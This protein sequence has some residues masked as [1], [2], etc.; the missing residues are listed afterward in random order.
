MHSPLWFTFHDELGHLRTAADIHRTGHLFAHNPI[1]RA[2]P[3]FPVL[4]MVASALAN[5]SGLSI[6][7]SGLIV[8]G[9]ARLVTVVALFRVYEFVM[10]SRAAALATILYASN[11]TF[12]YFDGQFSYESLAVALAPIV[13][14]GIVR[15]ARVPGIV[16]GATLAVGVVLT[17]HLTSYALCAFLAVW[18]VLAVVA[19][20]R[21]DEAGAVVIAAVA[22]VAI[23][24]AVAWA[25][26]AAPVTSGYIAPV[27][28]NAAHALV[29]LTGGDAAVKRPFQG[30]G[31][32]ARPVWERAASIGSIV[33]ISIGVLVGLG[34][35]VRRRPGALG[36]ALALTGAAYP[37]TLVPRLTQAGT[38]IS[39]RSSGFVFVGVGYLLALVMIRAVPAPLHRRVHHIRWGLASLA[40]LAVLF[41]GGVGI[42]WAPAA[43]QPGPFMP[44]ANSR[45]IDTP[46]RWAAIWARSHLQAG[47][48]L[49]GDLDSSLLM[50]A[51]A[52][53]NPQ[54]GVISGIPVS[55]LFTSTRLGP[56]ERR[57]IVGDQ[58]RYIVVD[59]RLSGA[60]PGVGFY[61]T[62]TEPGA[63]HHS[64]PIPK[65]ALEKFH[66]APFLDEVFSDGRISIYDTRHLL[67]GGS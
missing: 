64:H 17:H 26:L 9:V 19:R 2:S 45:S 34:A 23:V 35:A 65:P 37:L 60:L 42:G 20:R 29:S 61:F 21:S 50:A 63:F 6:F 18:T 51:Y 46:S 24:V 10:P 41:V 22:A 53:Q 47:E 66:S 4:E 43:L 48:R 16:L 38:E 27:V 14:L 62:P 28:R 32:Y 15:L 33:I 1:L 8:I 12:L 3:F 11:P 67:S 31:G 40:V 55:R 44:A 7:A 56:V 59:R 54:S 52:G 30:S 5:L 57:I 49:T 58:L 36:W 13:I 25:D 39:N